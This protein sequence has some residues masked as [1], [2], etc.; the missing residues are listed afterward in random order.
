MATPVDT[1]HAGRFSGK[2]AFGEQL[3]VLHEMF[4]YRKF[5][6]VDFL[7]SGDRVAVRT[8]I[9]LTRRSTGNEFIVPAA[10]FWTIRDGKVV[11]LIEYYDTALVSRM[12]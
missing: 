4:E 7:E 1:P 5:D 10:D 9:H 6:P 2:A 3:R 11:E 8:E 12:L